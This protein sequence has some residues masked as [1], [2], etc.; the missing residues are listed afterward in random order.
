[1]S[2]DGKNG[3][4]RLAGAVAGMGSGMHGVVSISSV[5][6]LKVSSGLT[7]VVISLV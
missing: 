2:Q 5:T 7:K 4:V 3:Q 6:T 1:M